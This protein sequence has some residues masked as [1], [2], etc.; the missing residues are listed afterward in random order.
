MEQRISITV[1]FKEQLS[2]LFDKKQNFS[3]SIHIF[4]EK[5]T[6]IEEKKKE[7]IQEY[8]KQSPAKEASTL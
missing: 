2:F 8:K 1:I 6:F 7:R 3:I 5:S 4:D